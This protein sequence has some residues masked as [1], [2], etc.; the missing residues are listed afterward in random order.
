MKKQNA[1]LLLLILVTP[2]F[3]GCGVLKFTQDALVCASPFSNP[4]SCSY[5][6]AQGRT[7]HLEKLP[8]GTWEVIEV[9]GPSKPY[10]RDQYIDYQVIGLKSRLAKTFTNGDCYGGGRSVT[11]KHVYKMGIVS[12]D[13]DM[14]VVFYTDRFDWK[15]GQEVLQPENYYTSPTRRPW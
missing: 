9:R 2:L 10:C 6:I 15:V 5:L 7:F 14:S 3:G 12:P 8:F 4:D 13:V 1:Y 11:S